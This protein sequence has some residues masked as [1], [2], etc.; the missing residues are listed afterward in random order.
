MLYDYSHLIISFRHD[1]KRTISSS[2]NTEPFSLI[3]RRNITAQQQDSTS[4]KVN[5]QN[6]RSA[7]TLKLSKISDNYGPIGA[8][9]GERVLDYVTG[10][11]IKGIQTV[12]KMLLVNSALTAI[13]EVSLTPDGRLTIN[14]PSDETLR[15]YL[16]TNSLRDLINSEKGLMITLRVISVF[17][18]IIGGAFSMYWFCSK[19]EQYAER[20]RFLRSRQQMDEFNERNDN[21]GQHCTV[22]LSAPRDVVILPCGHICICS[23]CSLMVDRCPV[24]RGDIQSKAAVF[25]S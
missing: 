17:F 5:V 11:Q 4:I 23:T 10:E 21:D 12:E 3:N 15:Y 2:W 13:G 14:F 18:F 19:Y 6:P 20:E 7:Y 16:T 9:A 22:C 25:Y 1:S 24:C 8:S